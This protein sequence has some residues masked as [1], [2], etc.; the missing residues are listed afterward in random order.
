MTAF[1][2]TTKSNGVL[3]G[4]FAV[5]SVSEINNNT[6]GETAT[7][8]L[9]FREFADLTVASGDTYT[10]EAGDIEGYDDIVVDGTLVVDDNATLYGNSLTQND[11]STVTISENNGTL[12]IDQGSVQDID[13]LLT[14]DED[15]GSYNTTE[16]LS[17]TQYYREQ[18]SQ[19]EIDSLV[20]GVEPAT[21]LQDE[22]ITG[23]WG[24]VND[25]QDSRNNALSIR[26]LTITVDILAQFDEY[27]DHTA[28]ENALQ[29]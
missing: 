2:I 22:N 4:R 26:R 10:V 9:D 19:S 25:I 14:F 18:I 17:N 23:V 11:G 20:F 29:L 21:Q 27:A 8:A 1:T 15:A 6:R 16:S 7:F 28:L 5:N 3:V 13:T 12:S 24:L